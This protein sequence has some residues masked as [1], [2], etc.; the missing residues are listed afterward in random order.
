MIATIPGT[1]VDGKAFP[2]RQAQ[3][4]IGKHLESHLGK[5][6]GQ[7][8][9]GSVFC[10]FDDGKKVL[11]LRHKPNMLGNAEA[12]PRP[13]MQNKDVPLHL[14]TFLTA[15]VACYRTNWPGIFIRFVPSPEE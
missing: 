11:Q 8:F 3:E 10:R 1:D 13:Q 2:A 12:Q 9:P 4:V 7:S 5:N 14:T 15:A 6:R